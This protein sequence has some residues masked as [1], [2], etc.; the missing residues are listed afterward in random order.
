MTF[1]A[2]GDEANAISVDN[3]RA[4]MELLI[5]FLGDAL[6]HYCETGEMLA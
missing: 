5:T 4:K 6:K 3:I 2:L 1:T